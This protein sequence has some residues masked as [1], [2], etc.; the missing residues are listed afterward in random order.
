MKRWIA[1]LAAFALG[2]GVYGLCELGF[3]GRTHWTMLLLG[4]VA[5]LAHYGMSA[6]PMPLWQRCLAGA[7]VITALEFPAGCLLN[8]RLGLG[9]WDYSH[10]WGALYGQICPLFSLIW[11][12]LSLPANLACLRLRQWAEA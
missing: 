7:A 8:L 5:V 10:H 11:A 6:L 9:I 4:G 3:R 12:G 1:P 2:G